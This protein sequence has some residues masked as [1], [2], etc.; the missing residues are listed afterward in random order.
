M[1]AQAI[2]IGFTIPM[3]T[4]GVPITGYQ[5]TATPVGPGS[6][7]TTSACTESPCTVSGLVNGTEYF[8]KVAAIN[9]AGIGPS[10]GASSIIMPATAALPV[11]S[12][13]AV[14]GD[15][16]VELSWS[17]LTTLQSGGGVFNRYEVYKRVS[18]A[19]V[20]TLV[21]DS[22]TARS[23]ADFTVTGLV[24]GTSYEF[25]IV[26]ITVAN[27][28]E[29]SGHPA[30]V[31]EYPSTVPSAVQSLG[32]VAV[33]P[34]E[35]IV[36]WSAP[37]SDGGAALSVPSY[38]VT[39]SASTP[40]ASFVMCTP[41][42]AQPSCLAQGLTHGATYSFTVV[43]NNRMGAGVPSS[44]TYAVPSVPATP[45]AAG[46]GASVGIPISPP[47]AL[48]NGA[49]IGAVLQGGV[50][51]RDVLLSRNATSSGWDAVSSGFALSVETMSPSGSSVALD[52]DGTMRVEPR[53]SVVASGL[54]YSPGTELA[55]FAI[56]V[57]RAFSARS[58]TGAV[59]LGSVVASA[60]GAVKMNVPISPDFVLGDYVLQLNGI[61]SGDEV[62]SVNLRLAVT[63]LANLTSISMQRS[64]FFQPRSAQMSPNGT[65]KLAAM[66]S[67]ILENEGDN[68]GTAKITVSAVSVSLD[69]PEANLAL[70]RA[71]AAAL[72]QEL[73]QNGV[74]G[75]FAVSVLTPTALATRH[76]TSSRKPLTTLAV[77]FRP[78]G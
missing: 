8:V 70:A 42:G 78:P 58:A 18:G 44:I 62:L 13:A 38:S 31:A 48:M 30:I 1:S 49:A 61:V 6:V 43:A 36:S 23:T 32:V 46:G 54:G 14:P 65:R 26:A 71:R 37:V 60:S 74:A 21:T 69:T 56:P 29:L 16:D 76:M 12:L 50:L 2:T 41:V 63:E 77:S 72:V 67:L 17:A 73:N 20:W 51:R 7:V 64:G 39:V 24:N 57:S 11:G 47:M 4:G 15:G 28:V 5:L 45:P 68:A 59:Y 25:Q 40:D 27:A 19:F 53:G 35:L 55:V 9:D 34:T 22:L 52:V 75:Q 33:E 66:V 10:S 3:F